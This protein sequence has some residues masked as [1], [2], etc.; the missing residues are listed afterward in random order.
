MRRWINE[1]AA[2]N[3][4]WVVLAVILFI[5]A[6]STLIGCS[7]GIDVDEL[8][9]YVVDNRDELIKLANAIPTATPTP[10]PT[11]TPVP[12]PPYQEPSGLLATV[13]VTGTYDHPGVCVCTASYVAAHLGVD[14]SG[15]CVAFKACQV[16]GI[17]IDYTMMMPHNERREW[18]TAHCACPDGAYNWIDWG[19][20]GPQDKKPYIYL[21]S[22]KE[23]H[24]DADGT[25]RGYAWCPMVGTGDVV[26]TWRSSSNRTRDAYYCVVRQVGEAYL[27]DIYRHD[28]RGD[29]GTYSVTVARS[30]QFVEVQ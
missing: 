29:G 19:D 13:D 6:C 26:I 10:E 7:G 27:M 4:P 15:G 25:A 18:D 11:A 2:N 14:P 17:T 20:H 21:T 9:G 12:P 8:W 30:V 3:L 23:K 22:Y 28:Q 1:D 16:N 24:P 5:I